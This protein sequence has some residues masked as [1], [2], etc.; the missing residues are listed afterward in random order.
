MKIVKFLQNAKFILIFSIFIVVSTA[1]IIYFKRPVLGSEFV[2]GYKLT[3]FASENVS[4][5]KIKNTLKSD[6]PKVDHVE[7]N[8]DNYEVYFLE[9]VTADKASEDLQKIFPDLG[10]LEI[11][12]YSP[13]MPAFISYRILNISL[14]SL[15]A[16]AVYILAVFKSV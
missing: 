1:L 8:G 9:S 13:I 2:D 6:F 3:F 14:L 4:E 5:M 12:E 15:L 10:E 16:F 11:Q 7:R